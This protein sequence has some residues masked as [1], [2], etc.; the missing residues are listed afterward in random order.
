MACNLDWVILLD[1]LKVFLTWPPLALIVIVIFF[2]RFGTEIA[3]FLT[4]VRPKGAVFDPMPVQ[5]VDLAPPRDGDQAGE[6]AAVEAAEQN[7]RQEDEPGGAAPGDRLVEVLLTNKKRED[8]FRY[9]NGLLVLSTQQLLD[10]LLLGGV[11]SIGEFNSSWPELSPSNRS[12]ILTVLYQHGLIDVVDDQVHITERG[13]EYANWPERLA[14]V[15]AQR[16]VFQSAMGFG[17]SALNPSGGKT[18]SEHNV[19]RTY[20]GRASPISSALAERTRRLRHQ[21]KLRE[22]VAR[23]A[24][25][26]TPSQ[27]EEGGDP[28]GDR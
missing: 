1:Y 11:M 21:E 10:M 13:R 9:L 25:M 18:L 16:G 24:Q 14:W 19:S 15:S 26:S 2:R 28:E 22:R 20:I 5:P 3:V 8:D 23:G 27:P 17:V 7:D 6:V 4:N 12:N